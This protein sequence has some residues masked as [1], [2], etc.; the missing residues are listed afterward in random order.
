MTLLDPSLAETL[1]NMS[2]SDVLDFKRDLSARMLPLTQGR[3]RGA[4]RP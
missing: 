2:E 3:V 4:L 1:L